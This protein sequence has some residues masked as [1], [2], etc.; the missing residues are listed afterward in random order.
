MAKSSCKVKCNQNGF[1][2][3][4]NATTACEVHRVNVD[5][6]NAKLSNEENQKYFNFQVSAWREIARWTAPAGTCERKSPTK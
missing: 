4:G 1:R 5:N 2:L 6:K 3:S